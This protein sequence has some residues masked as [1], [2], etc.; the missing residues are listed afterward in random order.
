MTGN[1]SS[2]D[3]PYLVFQFLGGRVALGG[4]SVLTDPMLPNHN[5]TGGEFTHTKDLVSSQLPKRVPTLV[6]LG[7]NWFVVACR[8]SFKNKD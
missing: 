8:H 2:S 7:V 1:Y 3:N 4:L 5:A 6:R